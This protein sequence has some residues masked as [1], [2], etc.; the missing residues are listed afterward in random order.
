MLVRLLLFVVLCIALAWAWRG[1]QRSRR[2]RRIESHTTE[3]VRCAQCALHVPRSAAIR[4]EQHWFCTPGHR[5]QYLES[6]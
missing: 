2:A 1:V 5:D 6:H 4:A 3:T